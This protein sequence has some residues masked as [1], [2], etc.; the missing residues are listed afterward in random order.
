MERTLETTTICEIPDSKGA[1]LNE[2][3]RMTKAVM[4]GSLSSSDV[5]DSILKDLLDV[6]EQPDASLADV[7]MTISILGQLLNGSQNQ[8][9]FR[10]DRLQVI[11]ILTRVQSTRHRMKSHLKH[12]N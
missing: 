2:L 7:E 12:Q 11:A 3:E 10:L 5:T 1:K 8:T 4:I 9:K 6:W